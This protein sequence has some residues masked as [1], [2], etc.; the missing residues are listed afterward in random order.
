MN[1][2][3]VDLFHDIVKELFMKI[4]HL[5]KCISVKMIVRQMAA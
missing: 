1:K 3:N 4:N 5:V 2:E